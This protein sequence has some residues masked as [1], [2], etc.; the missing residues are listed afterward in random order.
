MSFKKSNFKFRMVFFT[1]KLSLFD[2]FRNE[3]KKMAFSSF[4]TERVGS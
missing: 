2:F 4:T 1:E 3:Y